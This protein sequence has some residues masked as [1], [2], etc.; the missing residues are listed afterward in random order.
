MFLEDF[1][2]GREEPRKNTGRI[3]QVFLYVAERI[4]EEAINQV[5][6]VR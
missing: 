3:K 6:R 2:N 5:N 1:L 4:F